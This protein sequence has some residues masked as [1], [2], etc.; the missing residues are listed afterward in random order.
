MYGE[1]GLNYMYSVGLSYKENI[2]NMFNTMDTISIIKYNMTVY[3]V[4]CIS[5]KV[6]ITDNSINYRYLHVHVAVSV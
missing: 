4:Y 5:V 1:K 2:S 6:P 3:K